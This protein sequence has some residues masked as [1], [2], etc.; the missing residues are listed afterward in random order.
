MSI[1]Y[2]VYENVSIDSEPSIGEFV[3]IGVP[4]MGRMA[5]E[6]PTKIGRNCLLRSHTI[7]Y[8]GNQFGDRFQTGHGVLIREE[9]SIGHDVSIGSGS[10]IEHH[11]RVADNVR[12]HSG[13]FIP[14]YSILEHDCWIGPCVVFT[15]A[16]YPRSRG[17]KD[18]LRGPTIKA[19]AKIGANAT[20]LPGIV[21]G[22]HALVGAGAV[23]TRDVPANKVVVGNPARI[24]KDIS[25]LGVYGA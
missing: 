6:L 17:V 4:P 20:L 19:Y 23:V 12:I 2:R 8:A 11:V 25:E 22:E 13:V 1:V 16:L 10:I 5:G 21:I 3:I 9:N 14:E 15:N 18:S 7:I 24:V